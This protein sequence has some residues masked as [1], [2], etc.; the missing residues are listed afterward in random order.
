MKA[1]PEQLASQLKGAPLPVYL[2]TGDEPLLIEESCDLLRQ[3]L[4][5][6]GFSERETL[7]AEANFKWTYLLEC[8]NALSL[9][10]E[11]KIIELR[12]GGSKPNKQ[13]SEILREYLANPAPDNVLL[14]IADKLDGAAQKSAW[15]KAIDKTGMIVQIWPVEAQQLPG[16]LNNRAKQ[17]G[18]T[19]DRD[20]VQ[21]LC[22]R[23]EGNLLAAKQELD[24]LNLLY[25]GQTLDADQVIDSVSDSSRY[26]IYGLVDAALLQ[27]TARCNKIIQ[28]LRQEGTEAPVA[29]WAISREVR[30]LLT[31]QQGLAQGQQY[32][33]ICQ[34]ERIWGK[35][36]GQLQ[37]AARRI[38][39]QALQ[40]M[41]SQ[42]MT[43]DQQI[44]GAPGDAWLTLNS[45]VLRLSGI[46]LGLAEIH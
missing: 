1:K 12:L 10:A 42:C 30:T 39:P 2:V 34:K 14:I 43:V 28:V 20:A 24:K 13:A 19:L 3:Y 44:K 6:Q 9:F 5:D 8:A 17:I 27:Q 32:E 31:V 22:E 33:A 46:E 36:K 26:D 16:W 21:L 18:L 11:K 23:V 29:L 38:A 45:I 40:Q 35:R 41:L 15:F 7:H 4:V 37:A 25:P